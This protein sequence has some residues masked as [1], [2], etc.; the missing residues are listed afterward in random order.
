MDEYAKTVGS[1]LRFKGRSDILEVERKRKKKTKKKKEKK[2]KKKK[3]RKTENRKDEEDVVPTY[4]PV[5]TLGSGRFIT[6]GTSVMG[7]AGT[8]FMS[9]LSVGDCVIV[10]HPTSLKD[11]TRIVTMVLS[12]ISIS[13]SSPFSTDL[14]TPSKFHFIKAPP[15]RLDEEK[16][17]SR[18]KKRKMNE[19]RSAFGTYAAMTN[20]GSSFTYRVKKK[21]LGTSY[22]V[23]TVRAGE[24]SREELL[25]MRSKKKSDRMCSF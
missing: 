1:K 8:S 10:R 6:S 14:V 7:Q 18:K 22:K 19:E 20:E 16:E 5:K 25:N 17:R 21:G 11:E 12:Q 2:K 9:E 23:V 13:L 24:H 15:K 3:K 4:V